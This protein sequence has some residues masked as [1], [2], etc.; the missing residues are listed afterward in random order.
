M[1][2]APGLEPGCSC[3]RWILNP[4]R[5][6]IPPSWLG[7]FESK[8]ERISYISSIICQGVILIDKFSVKSAFI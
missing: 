4:L 7:Y 3:E 5:L 8:Q 6:P 2:P 1:V